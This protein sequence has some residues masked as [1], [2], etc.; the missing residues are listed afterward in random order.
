M[1]ELKTVKVSNKKISVVKTTKEQLQPKGSDWF[2]TLYPNI[3]LVGKKKSGKTSVI[4]NILEH[5]CDKK[6]VFIFVV[7]TIDKDDTWIQ[8]SKKWRKKGAEVLAYTSFKDPEEGNIIENFVEEQL[9]E[10]ADEEEEK[11]AEEKEKEQVGKGKFDCPMIYCTANGKTNEQLFY[12]KQKKVAMKEEKKAKTLPKIG[13]G[14][15]KVSPDFC[16]VFDD[17]TDLTRDKSLSQ[18]LKKNRHFKLMTI[19]SSQDVSD[20]KPDARK[21]M[22][23]VLLFPRI[24]IDKLEKVRDNM[25]LPISFDKFS[26]IYHDATNKPYNFLYVSRDDEFRHNFTHKYIDISDD[27]DAEEVED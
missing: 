7:A 12:E 1:A 2:S 18:L 8:I 9:K 16:F 21:Q 6:T 15:K 19:I 4:A 17:Q 13:R 23:Y 10:A 3:W 20:L 27:S 14:V 22:D 11:E 26:E 24:D 5:C 25:G